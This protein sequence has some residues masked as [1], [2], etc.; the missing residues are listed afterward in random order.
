MVGSKLSVDKNPWT[1][2]FFA[3]LV[4]T[5]FLVFI[6]LKQHLNTVPYLNVLLCAYVHTGFAVVPTLIKHHERQCAKKKKSYT[7]HVLHHLKV[8]RGPSKC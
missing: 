1:Y 7:N 2:P 6:T 8:S 3:S 5:C 4:Q